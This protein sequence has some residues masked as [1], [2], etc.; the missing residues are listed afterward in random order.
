[1][2]N[3]K[4]E[5]FIFGAA[6]LVIVIVII[7]VMITNNKADLKKKEILQK[8]QHEVDII[9]KKK[10]AE[11]QKEDDLYRNELQES[12]KKKIPLFNDVS[13]LREKINSLKIGYPTAYKYNSYNYS[14]STDYF[15]FGSIGNK[16]MKNNA[17]I[18]LEGDNIQRVDLAKIVI[19][20]NNKNESSS[21]KAKFATLSK[22]LLNLLEIPSPKG[23]NSSISTPKKFH[24]ENEKYEI[25]IVVNH[26]NI[27]EYK[28]LIYTK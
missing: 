4:K 9:N 18:Y 13:L 22:K 15:E 14:S 19:N 23:F 26:F 6:V 1:M 8:E 21:A 3:N 5:K 25:S 12:Y 7:S 11:L 20:V 16:G 2:E 28:L 24:Y 10:E 17:A 27:D